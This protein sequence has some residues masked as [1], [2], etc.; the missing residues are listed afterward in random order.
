VLRYPHVKIEVCD[1]SERRRGEIELEQAF[2]EK[3]AELRQSQERLQTLASELNLAE[4]REQKRLANELHDHLL[5][6]LVAGERWES[7]MQDC[8]QILASVMNG[9]T[10]VSLFPAGRLV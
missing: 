9:R 5:Q 2:N 8:A 6:K 10:G 3:T 7:D 4:Q 1:L